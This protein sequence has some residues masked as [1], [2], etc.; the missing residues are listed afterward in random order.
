MMHV[1]YLQQAL[2]LAKIRRGFCSPNPAVGAIIVNEA[3]EILATGYHLGAGHAHAEVDALQK[4]NDKAKDATIYIT[5]EPCCHWGRT[6]P[7]TD[8]IIQSGIK[9]VFYAMK[10]PNPIV[11][12]KS[13]MIL[14]KENIFCEHIEIPEI[15]AFYQSYHYWQQTKKPF[16]TGKIALSLDGKIAGKKGEPIQITGDALK[17]LTYEHRKKSDA[18]LTTAK[19]IISD[20]PQMN[21]R[22]AETIA[23]PI[24][25]LDRELKISLNAKIFS[26]AKSVTLFHGKNVAPERLEMFLQHNIRC[27]EIPVVDEKLNL[28]RVMEEIGKDGIQDLW[29]EAGGTCF[30]EM[31]KQHL[32]HKMLIYVA[33][34]WLGFGL[35]AF[36]PGFSL[37]YPLESISWKKV[38]HDA[39]CE[40]NAVF[41]NC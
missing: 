20:D 5:L 34:R 35:E 13:K 41:K 23:K 36:P 27:I 39:V 2:E 15:T 37:N 12:G 29:V 21:V 40:I 32:L 26:T 8:A 17:E 24:Y 33:P 30:A 19:T 4:L 38:G 3:G 28:L 6:P 18:I 7:C 9:K 10:D 1:A 16:V 14:A 25:I 31:A 11:S 22:G